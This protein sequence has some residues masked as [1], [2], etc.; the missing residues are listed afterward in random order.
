M[1]QVNAWPQDS[2][3]PNSSDI[4][5]NLMGDVEKWHND[6]KDNHMN[7]VIL[8]SRNFQIISFLLQFHEIFEIFKGWYEWSF[9]TSGRCIMWWN[10]SSWCLLLHFYICWTGNFM[11]CFWFRHFLISKH[12]VIY[13]PHKN[14]VKVIHIKL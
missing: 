3:V 12:T 6:V 8:I 10:V 2:Q 11:S 7:K 9:N 4:L 5:I 1:Y 14:L 13:I